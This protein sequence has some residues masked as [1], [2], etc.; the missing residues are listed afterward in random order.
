MVFLLIFN[1]GQVQA[2]GLANLMQYAQRNGTMTNIN[3]GKV[4]SDQQA[5]YVTGAQLSAEVQSQKP[6]A[7]L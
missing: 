7:R 1:V 4:V 5:G 6:Y 2:S 3:K